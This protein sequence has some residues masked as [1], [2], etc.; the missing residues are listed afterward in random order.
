MNRLSLRVLV[1]LLFCAPAS[2]CFGP[3][4]YVG[5]PSGAD[6][7]ILYALVSLYVKE[8]T[9][10][11]SVSVP[12]EGEGGVELIRQE[13]I[14]MAFAGAPADGAEAI[15]EIAG[16]P[17]MVSGPRPL[18]D[19]Q[20]TTVV[21]ALKKLGRL[22]TAEHLRQLAAEVARGAAPAAAVRN[23]LMERRWI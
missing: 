6:G 22:V 23:L 15:L 1:L 17:L 12:L 5:V 7:E 21:P 8:K 3:K 18:N 4:L 10:V 19:L 16:G 14:D 11:E 13:K 20:F 2:A 9:G